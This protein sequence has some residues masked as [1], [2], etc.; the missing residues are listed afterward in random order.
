MGTVISYMWL[1]FVKCFETVHT[2]HYGEAC[3]EHKRRM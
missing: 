2:L 1:I 3:W